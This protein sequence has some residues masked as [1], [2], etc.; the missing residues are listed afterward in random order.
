MTVDNPVTT[1]R[2]GKA[3]PIDSFTSEDITITFD[4]WLLTLEQAATWNGWMSDETLMQ[5]AGHLRERA[6]QEWK[7]LLPENRASYQVAVKAL[8]EKLD[9]GNQILAAL[10]FHPT[11]Q[12]SSESV[13][14]FIT[15]LEKVFQTGFGHE[16][17]SIETIQKDVAMWTIAGRPSVY[18]PICLQGSEL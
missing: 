5:L 8:R 14:D 10:D 16:H 1:L 12:Q 3:P 6:S 4:D 11:S 18:I 17:L 15:R 9:S 2:H 13:S 7:L